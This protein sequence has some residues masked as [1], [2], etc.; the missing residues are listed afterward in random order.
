MTQCPS[1]HSRRVPLA[2]LGMA[3]L[4]CL[5]PSLIYTHGS[6]VPPN[7]P[8]RLERDAASV[9]LWYMDRVIF[10]ANLDEA[11][12]GA[13]FVS[14]VES[15][16][17][18]VEQVFK[19]TRR[20]QSLTLTG[21]VAGGPEAFPC[22]VAPPHDGPR[23]V[24]HALGLSHSRLN[25][26][27]YD[28]TGDWV[29]SVDTPAAVDIRPVA[30]EVGPRR[31]A[32]SA[33]GQEIIL[34]FRP[35]YYQK[36]RGLEFYE[37]WTYRAWDRPV[38]GWCS[39]F[40]HFRD[41]SGEK[42]R[43]AAD[44][45][46]AELRPWG[47][48][49]LQMDDG[50]QQE[51][52]GRPATWLEPNDKFPAGLPALS[53][54]IRQK[55]LRPGIWTYTSFHQADFAR[56]NPGYFVRNHQGEP[57]WGNWVGYVLDAANPATLADI[58][59][60]IY[61]GFRETG[62]DYF[63]VDALRHLRYEGYNSHARYFDERGVDRV[64]A[65]R[66]LVR[67]IREEIGADCFMLGCW[68][69]RPELVGLIDGCRIGTDGFG[70]G[71]LAQY[72]SFNNVVWR[73]DPDHIELTPAEA[74]RSSMVTSLTGSLFMLTDKPEVYRTPLAD[75]ARRAIP[76]PVTVPG[77]IYDVDPARSA[78]LHRADT[79]LSG[80]GPR[81]LDA[82]QAPVCHLY[83]LEINRPFERW[84]VLGRTGGAD[85]TIR[86]EHL[87]LDA[88]REYLVFEFWTGTWRGSFTGSF[89][90]GPISPRF[91]CQLFVI[92]ERQP[93][94]QLL[95]TSRHI[96]AGGVDLADVAWTGDTLAGVSRLVRGDPYVLHVT[97]P[98]GYRLRA[99][100]C[101]GATVAGN[102]PVAGTRRIRLET[103]KSGP[104]T[105][106]LTYERER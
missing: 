104:V 49:Y 30:E 14:L 9:R 101:D 6:G 72:N 1:R 74:W 97:E 93:R 36:H 69:I 42:I 53:G 7:E 43:A 63:K 65:Y 90:P 40:A 13:E 79:E 59:R 81:A 70:Y 88:D 35:R 66:G 60:P 87:G 98:A 18:R 34:R 83:L 78:M 37:P 32:L 45:L 25:R 5:F 96:T 102:E 103:E 89:E 10:A 73:N 24:R 41:I 26:A 22:A 106:T 19:W 77:Q 54:Y 62:W 17:D 61:R 57:V 56:D 44:V 23:L 8:A 85:G 3:A 64:A 67:A 21:A 55:G 38:V 76:V 47:L 95:A 68:G 2:V 33:A 100:V 12:Q 52:A 50:Y 99:V 84:V 82:D 94:P 71:G 27:V 20:G 28:R 92:R 75:A 91:N 4:C 86:F 39:W 80:S 105:W 15:R 16:N 11:G 48:E 31:F 58:I 29:L 46:A 51:P